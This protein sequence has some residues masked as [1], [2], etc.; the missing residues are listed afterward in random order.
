MVC[1]HRRVSPCAQGLEL[2]AWPAESQLWVFFTRPPAYKPHL[3]EAGSFAPGLS[4]PAPGLFALQSAPS[5]R[6]MMLGGRNPQGFLLRGR[7]RIA[8]GGAWSFVHGVRTPGQWLFEA[9]GWVCGGFARRF[10]DARSACRILDPMMFVHLYC[11]FQQ[12]KVSKPQHQ[13][14]EADFLE[15]S[16]LGNK[17][18]EH[19]QYQEEQ[20]RS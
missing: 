6:P 1:R 7:V 11:R 12:S 14:A 15:N 4:N 20:R 19:S 13:Y 9:C 16:T 17:K 5:V 2:C 18:A 3:R 8:A 10:R